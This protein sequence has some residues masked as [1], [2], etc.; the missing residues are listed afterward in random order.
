MLRR[1]LFCSYACA[2]EIKRKNAD[3]LNGHIFYIKS[4]IYSPFNI[5][6]KFD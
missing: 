2:I 1:G 4:F 3:N 6:P 5:K